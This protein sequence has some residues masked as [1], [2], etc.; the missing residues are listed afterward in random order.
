VL[1][2]FY[3]G[4]S[5]LTHGQNSPISALCVSISL[6]EGDSLLTHG[7]NSLISALCVS[8]SLYEGVFL[9]NT[10]RIGR[11]LPSVCQ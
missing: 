3:E 10:N 7:L 1:I 2:S 6:Y 4:A 8:I 5:F 11:F 9:L